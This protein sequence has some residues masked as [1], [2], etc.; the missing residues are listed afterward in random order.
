MPHQQYKTSIDAAI[1]CAYECEHC[2]DACM[3]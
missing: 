2:A 1:H 3:G